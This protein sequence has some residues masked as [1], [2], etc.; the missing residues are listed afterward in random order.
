MV[1]VV[2]SFASLCWL[3]FCLAGAQRTA[4]VSNVAGFRTALADGSVTRIEVLESLWLSE[5][6]WAP[7]QT[8]IRIARNLTLASPESY[9]DYWVSIQFNYISQR[10]QLAPRV[11][12]LIQRMFTHGWRRETLTS[13]PGVLASLQLLPPSFAR[14]HHAVLAMMQLFQYTVWPSLHHMFM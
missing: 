4:L 1:T 5:E 12:L 8:P 13:L 14:W 2:A 11:T 10:L 7:T 9:G 3:L 6:E